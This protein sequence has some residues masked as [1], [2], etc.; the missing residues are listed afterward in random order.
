MGLL[1][2]LV[3]GDAVR[4]ALALGL[5][6]PAE[7]VEGLVGLA[8][9]TV[10]HALIVG[11]E[12][13]T[14]NE[15]PGA[16]LFAFSVVGLPAVAGRSET[17]LAG[18]LGRLEAPFGVDPVVVQG[19]RLVVDAGLGVALDAVRCRATAIHQGQGPEVGAA[20]QQHEEHQEPV[21]QSPLSCASSGSGTRKPQFGQGSPT[22]PTHSTSFSPHQQGQKP[23]PV[24]SSS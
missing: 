4:L 24:P 2:R 14:A 1:V 16:R 10:L 19:P 9:W 5:V 12:P 7:L 15:R 17:R 6:L 20:G 3:A 18:V 21:H 22:S 8:A 23:L 11:L 13:Q